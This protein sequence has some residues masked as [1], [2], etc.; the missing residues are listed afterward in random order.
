MPEVAHRPWPV[1][2]PA[3]GNVGACMTT[4]FGGTSIG[5]FAGLN[6]ADHVQD[7]PFHVTQN[8]E[9]LA[10]HVGVRPVFLHQVHGIHCLELFPE[11]PDGQEADASTTTQ[12]GLGC[13]V[14]VADCLP[15]LLCDRQ[16]ARVAA[17]HA[18]W[19]GLLAG[20]L[21]QSV[22]AFE[23]SARILAWLGPCIGPQAFEVGPEVRA[24]Y[25]AAWGGQV[26]TFSYFAPIPNGK[27]WCN[28]AEL[29]RWRLS[30]LGIEC[31][32]GN[33]GSDGWCT[34]GNPGPWFSHRR[35]GIPGGGTGRMAACVWIKP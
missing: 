3:P 24:A 7:D 15:V 33:D 35:N 2:W 22:T 11:V 20:V 29:A 27:F 14:M 25:V 4:R 28:L 21:D 12:V 1:I 34:V 31:V 19:R 17:A 32:Y 30:Q 18:G 8:R 13:T 10:A 23:P 9:Q 26:G 16:G 6:L 5:A